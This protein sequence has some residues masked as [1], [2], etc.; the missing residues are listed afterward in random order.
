MN[1]EYAY[2]DAIGVD[3][4]G[5]IYFSDHGST[6]KKVYNGVTTTVAGNGT[7]GYGG[8]GGP[9]IDA[10]LSTIRSLAFDNTGSKLALADQNN[11]R[12][13]L[14]TFSSGSSGQSQNN[15]NGIASKIENPNNGKI[16]L[17][18]DLQTGQDE[19]VAISVLDRHG[20]EIY[21]DKIFAEKGRLSKQI[22]LGDHIGDG[23]Y[24]LWLRTAN[25]KGVSR[26]VI[27]K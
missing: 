19:T 8:D 27:R 17:D 4:I 15:L 23:V 25:K 2:N 11:N 3:T 10:Q 18:G 6:V 9:A 14:V 12:I 21:E 1:N 22:Q 13:R 16:I 24:L 7:N 5:A 20:H 26:F